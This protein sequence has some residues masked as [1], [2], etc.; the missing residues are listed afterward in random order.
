MPE[1]SKV[2]KYLELANIDISGNI[3]GC[4]ETTGENLPT[5][6]RRK[7]LT[8]DVIVSSVEGSLESVALIPKEYNNALCSTGFH[9]LRPSTISPKYL[10]IFMKS[11]L[12]Q[13]LL[14]K[15]C[16]GTILPS[17]GEDEISQLPL[18]LLETGI[19]GTINNKVSQA[20]LIRQYSKN[21]LQ[22]TKR[23]VEIAIESGETKA[24][25]WLER[26]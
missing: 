10:F 15:D 19:Q 26:Q 20:V 4:T 13:S 11:M 12:G 17:I 24:K 9:V 14:K 21:I 8:N 2:Y 1:A 23:A 6:A 18:P 7:V 25:A 5:R 22:A 3:L 16:S